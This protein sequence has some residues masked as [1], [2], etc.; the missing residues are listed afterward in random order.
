VAG[1]GP[2]HEQSKGLWIGA[3]EASDANRFAPELKERRLVPVCLA[4]EDAQRHYEGYSN[5]VLWPLCHYLLEHVEF[6]GPDYEAYARVNE[7]F[8]EAVVQHAR[9]DDTIWIHDY[10]LMLLPALL[11]ERLPH[12]R[13]GFF[14]H[15]PFPSSEVFRILP[16]KEEIL[17][18]LLGANLIGL[19]TYDYARHLVSTFRRVLAVEFD[20]EW[21]RQS[22]GQCRIGVFPLGVDTPGLRARAAQPTVERRVER[23]RK[24]VQGRRVILGV[25]RMDYTKGLPQ[26]LDG[27]A[28]FLK[29][30]PEWREKAVLLQLAVPSR[31]NIQSYKH[32]KEVVDQH[33][34]EINGAYQNGPLAPI[35][36]MYRSV[37]ADELAALYRLA[38]VALVTPTRDGMNLV[39]KEYV[40]SRVD[41]TGVLVLSEFAGAAAEMGEALLVNPHDADSIARALETALCMSEGERVRRMGALRRR[42][43][44][45]TVH[46]WVARFLK[47]LEVFA[48]PEAQ[49]DGRT[50]WQVKSVQAFA[51]AK[52]ALLALDYDGTLTPLV[53]VPH[54]ARPTPELLK[55]LEQLSKLPGVD[56]AVISGR[57]PETLFEW[58]SHLDIHLVAEHGFHRRLR[59]QAQWEAFEKGLDVSWKSA[60]HEILD[61]YT[62]RAPGSFIEEKP[63]S[64]VWH[65]RQAEHGFGQWLARE[66]GQH[67]SETF[68]NSPLTVLHGNKVVEVRP[69]GFDKGKA[70]LKLMAHLGKVDYLLAAG[71]DR[72]DEDMFAVA[73]ATAWTIKVGKVGS[74]AD[75]SHARCHLSGPEA[76][77]G[78]LLQLLQKR[79]GA[80]QQ[81]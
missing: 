78:H 61:D 40:A 26:R 63:V 32:L 5:Q 79:Q 55:L 38:D 48:V 14:L 41:D 65:Y 33:V 42:V 45:N 56:V 18:G 46:H 24:Q 27:F 12:A 6:D 15:I 20:E 76:V 4:K 72:T 62:T 43:A 30:R 1:L 34:G 13:I 69:Q 35:I 49:A 17:R 36:Y 19:H 66:L 51:T 68:A 8:A 54:E 53:R 60:V 74:A 37:P 2:A 28:R 57:D 22:D 50:S 70:L 39:A 81:A 10:H 29:D 67:L 23:M 71:D 44:A 21:L 7:R 64:L 47:A 80:T 58:F 75:K 16:R 9:P 52:R 73:P 11:R 3:L 77:R 25:D 59:G 31:A